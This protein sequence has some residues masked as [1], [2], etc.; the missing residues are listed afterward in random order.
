MNQS[1]GQ[2]IKNLY[3]LCVGLPSDQQLQYIA[4]S[5]YPDAV[6]L[7]VAKLLDYSGDIDE[8]LS[9]VILETAQRGLNASS[10]QAGEK[11]DQYRLL[12]HI[13][14]GGQGEVWLA[15]RDD[16]E[17]NHR[18]AIKFIKLSPNEYELKRFQTEREF[19]A[20]LQHANIASL[21]GGGQYNDRLYMIM[22][23]VDGIPLMDY[24]KQNKLNLQQTLNC[25]LEI[26]RA[27]SYAHSKGIIHRDI[28][29]SNIL[30]TS[31]GVVKLLDFGI[32]KTMD[33]ETTI[34]QGAAMMTMAYSSPEQINGESVTTAT[35]VY[36]LGL[37]LYELLTFQKAQESTTESPAEF[38][39]LVTDVIPEKPSQLASRGHSKF[40]SRVLQ[41]DLDN[42]VMMSIRKEADRRYINAD[43]MI[44]DINNFLESRPLQ[45]SGDSFTYRMTKLLK[46]N[47]L[48]SVLT[49]IVVS[50]LVILPI[51][52]HQNAEKLRLERDKAQQQA[53]IASKT[54]E[55]LSTL[56]ESATP[57]GHEGGTINLMS[58]L[59]QGERQLQEEVH[60]YPQVTAALTMTMGGIQHHLDK[61]PKAVEYY[62]KAVGLYQ[63]VN[64]KVGELNALGQL[65][66]MSFRVEDIENTELYFSQADAISDQVDDVSILVMHNIRKATVA[67][68]RGKKEQAIVFAE[69]ALQ[70][71]DAME[72]ENFGLKGRIYSELGEA[73]KFTDMEKSLQFN[74]RAIAYAEKDVGKVHPFYL[75]RI[76]SKAVRLMRMN[77]HKEAEQ[78]ID[79]TIDIAR[80]LYSE[81][82]P[83]YAFFLSPKATY[84]HDNGYFNETEILYKQ[85][86]DIH[87]AN[88]G[89]ENYEYARLINNLAYLHEDKGELEKA[90]DLYSESAALRKKL[91]PENLIR[92]ATTESNLARTLSKLKAYDQSAALLNRVMPVFESKKRNNLYNDITQMANTIADGSSQDSCSQGTKI[93]QELTPAIQKESEKSWRRLGAE[94]WIG[95]M[96]RSCGLHEQSEYWFKSAL[97]RSK[98]IY[99]EGSEGQEI[100]SNQIP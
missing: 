67:N 19:L 77:R 12:Q 18:V 52:M 3:N 81:Q 64:D 48:A 80:R 76:N 1:F 27:V 60:N 55:F 21:L 54:S 83:R 33:M 32:A 24:I 96:L 10:I 72:K 56:F 4:S 7:Q 97:D 37:V 65:A 85:L 43:A 95:H 39:R 61:T 41:G 59:E 70:E 44:V 69:L 13:G 51:L 57:L 22:E 98:N 53:L 73:Y 42:L 25:F 38:I 15:E 16:G 50:F 87:V 40:P 2:D 84:L 94:L 47:P 46:R 30:V 74:D 8:K 93:L 79:E 49:A 6:K 88:Y 75:G 78:Y 9:Q 86:I 91:D 23:W 26:C 35:D 68:E 36:A 71:L 28:K 100:V 5:D 20:S 62:Q 58:V 14:E 63:Q 92:V 89:N 99:Q 11:I 29:P 90:R 66:V 45:A 34:T 82:H 17:F 31:E